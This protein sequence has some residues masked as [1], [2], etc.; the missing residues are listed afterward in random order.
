MEMCAPILS[1]ASSSGL[2]VPLRKRPPAKGRLP[3]LPTL[4]TVY[5]FTLLLLS[6]ECEFL[7][8]REIV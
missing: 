6:P 8:G 3:V 4:N 1:I 7:E 5:L 2:E